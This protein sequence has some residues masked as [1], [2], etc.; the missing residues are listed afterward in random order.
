MVALYASDL[1]M[2]ALWE[3]HADRCNQT[4]SFGLLPPGSWS[5]PRPALPL[6]QV[7]TT[8]IGWIFPHVLVIRI[9]F[10]SRGQ[11]DWHLHAGLVIKEG[12]LFIHSRAQG[13]GNWR[14]EGVPA[15]HDWKHDMC[16]W[17]Q[18]K[19]RGCEMPDVGLV[20]YDPSRGPLMVVNLL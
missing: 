10:P 7:R 19:C 4:V 1:S 2:H 15:E 17:R 5:S 11:K 3:M 14:A 16:S 9:A 12:L 8:R 18:D 6:N 13:Q 20:W